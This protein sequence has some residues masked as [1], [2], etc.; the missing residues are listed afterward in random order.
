MVTSDVSVNSCSPKIPTRKQ[1]ASFYGIKVH[2]EILWVQCGEFPI[3]SV[4]QDFSNFTLNQAWWIWHIFHSK[5][6]FMDFTLPTKWWILKSHLYSFHVNFAH[7]SSIK[8]LQTCLKLKA[9]EGVYLKHCS[10]FMTE[11]K[12]CNMMSAE[13]SYLLLSY[14]SWDEKKRKCW[15]S[16][17]TKLC[18]FFAPFFQDRNIGS[19][20]SSFIGIMQNMA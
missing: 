9:F 8:C 1:F 2:T 20:F 11:Y 12:C 17:S 7:N 5:W 6:L 3:T 10:R 4:E 13:D 14:V 15:I 16:K 18:T 19:S